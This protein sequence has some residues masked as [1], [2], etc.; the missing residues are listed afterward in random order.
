MLVSTQE[1]KVNDKIQKIEGGRIYTVYKINS[2]MARI[3]DTEGNKDMLS[4]KK[5][6]ILVK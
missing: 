3:I 1:I 4:N 2:F 5:K 6:V